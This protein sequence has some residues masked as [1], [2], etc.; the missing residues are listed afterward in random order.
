M[1]AFEKC[2]ELG[3]EAG[4]GGAV[5][6]VV[7]DGQG[8]IQESR[9]M[10]WPSMTRGRWLIPPTMTSRDIKD[11]G[12]MPKPAPPANM[13][14]AVTATVPTRCRAA[15]DLAITAYMAG[16]APGIRSRPARLVPAI[17]R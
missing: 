15:T 5:H 11:R 13:P 12:V 8:E 14:T 10:T 6:Y 2:P 17:C 4:G 1:E 9:M 7:V 3:A 16:S